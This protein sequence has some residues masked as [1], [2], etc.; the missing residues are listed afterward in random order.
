MTRFQLGDAVWSIEQVDNRITTIE[1]DG[2]SKVEELATPQLA[3]TR[4]RVLTNQRLRTGWKLVVETPQPAPPPAPIVA[5]ARNPE[6]E[7]AILD[8]PEH[9]PSWL[10]Y[11]DWL[12]QQNDPRGT[13]IAL[14][15]AA[16]AAPDDPV[17]QGRLRNHLQRFSHYLAG[18]Y[19]GR[20]GWGFIEEIAISSGNVS[21]F[22]T[23]AGR[24]ITKVEVVE[25]R[26]FDAVIEAVG[27]QAP[28][29]I[30]DLSFT[31]AGLLGSLA[32]I[33]SVLA[34]LR[35]LD[36][37]CR[38]TAACLDHLAQASLPMLR[39]L[40]IRI[41]DRD[42]RP[43]LDR[44]LAR[45]GLDAL[46][47]LH[48]DDRTGTKRPESL[49]AMPIAQHLEVL[50]LVSITLDKVEELAWLVEKGEFPKLKELE[51]PIEEQDLPRFTLARLEARIGRVVGI[52][53]RYV[54]ISE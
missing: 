4:L 18:G 26:S 15:A 48:F 38:V 16:R 40:G 10:V 44:F 24:F 3:K 28:T 46:R 7:A 34:R 17:V 22:E 9:V 20:I 14:R 37:H 5:N 12:Q 27:N 33:E 11:G 1:P 42:L 2:S 31:R 47:S 21:V 54:R 25:P 35:V 51:L 13:H 19:A 45:S 43:A 6:L 36:I 52:R 41:E 8:D 30:R 29:T 39:H 50:V 49:A 53:S 23:H 32:P